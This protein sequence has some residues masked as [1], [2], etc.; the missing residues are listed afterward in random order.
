M[1]ASLPMY[2]SVANR[3]AN[4]QFWTLIRKSLGSGPLRLSRPDDLWSVWEHPDLLLSQTCSLPYRTRLR[5]KVHLVGTPDYALRGCPSGYYRSLLI[6][7]RHD[8][9]TV[10]HQFAGARFA[11]NDALSQSGWLAAQDHLRDMEADFTF[12][13]SVLD[14]GSHAASA[15][16][17]L[18]RR[19]D[20]AAIDAATWAM[21]S[22]DTPTVA[23]LRVIARTR[24]TPGLPL[25]TSATRDPAPILQAVRQALI[26]LP[27]A[28]RARLMLRDVVQIPAETYLSLPMPRV[29]ASVPA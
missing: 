12:E 27:A 11:R 7:R 8:R 20:I 25:I 6:V 23:G 21:L 29:E 1:T 19:A 14:T 5:D 16:A 4:D 15:Q 10:L 13:D 18:E 9:R 22:R 28:T 24:P 2:D 26:E 3:A 17:V